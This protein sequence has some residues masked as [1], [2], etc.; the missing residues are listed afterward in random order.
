MCSSD[1]YWF[2]IFISAP[3]TVPGLSVGASLSS[4]GV[5][6]T[7]SAVRGDFSKVTSSSVT[8]MYGFQIM[9]TITTSTSALSLSIRVIDSTGDSAPTGITF[10]GTAYIAKVGGIS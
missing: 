10:S 6:P 4:T 3:N 5:S 9:G 1:L 8:S 7:Y 2:H